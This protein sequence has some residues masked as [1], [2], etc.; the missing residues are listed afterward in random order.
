MKKSRI[1]ISTLCTLCVGV[2]ALVAGAKTQAKAVQAAVPSGA[3]T[4]SYDSSDWTYSGSGSQSTYWQLNA[5]SITYKGGSGWTDHMLLTDQFDTAVANYT[6]EAT[7]TGTINSSITDEAHCGFVPW[8]VDSNNWIMVYAQWVSW[9]RP[10]EI[11]SIDLYAKING[12]VH[13]YMMTYEGGA[14]GWHNTEEWHNNFTDGCGVLPA[15][16]FT[17]T[18]SKTRSLEAGVASDWFGI[19]AKKKDGTTFKVVDNIWFKVRDTGYVYGYDKPKVGFW[20]QKDTFSITDFSFTHNGYTT[21]ETAGFLGANAY[22]FFSK[23]A[24]TDLCSAIDTDAQGEKDA[25]QAAYGALSAKDLSSLA[26]VSYGG[27]KFNVMQAYDYYIAYANSVIAKK[28]GLAKLVG[29]DTQSTLIPL[30]VIIAV[31][32]ITFCGFIIIKRKSHN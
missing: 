31:T 9:D 6:V 17:L 14:W 24:T 32:A 26:N 21:D 23:V 12:D 19:V 18:V 16:G 8:Y 3:Q 29:V 5:D 4:V 10:T 1:L 11:R 2:G 30:V 28:S 7:F 20:C 15:D 22:A 13:V 25:L 27:G